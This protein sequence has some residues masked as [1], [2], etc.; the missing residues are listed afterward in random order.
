M[1]VSGAVIA[2]SLAVLAIASLGCA[3]DKTCRGVV[4]IGAQVQKA[5]LLK[6]DGSVWL[7]HPGAEDPTR[8]FSA[9]DA[10]GFANAQLC[11]RMSD[12]YVWC[13]P[14]YDQITAGRIADL[15]SVA[16][17]SSWWDEQDE[18]DCAVLQDGSL[19]CRSSYDSEFGQRAVGIRNVAVGAGHF[20][21]IAMDGTLDCQSE[22]GSPDWNGAGA[23]LADVV[24]VVSAAQPPDSTLR[25]A[26]GAVWSIHQL[27]RAYDTPI[28]QTQI[29]G[30]DGTIQ[31]MVGGLGFVCA[32]LSEGEVTC[33]VAGDATGGEVILQVDT[34]SARRTPQRIAS[35]PQPATALA[36][37]D[38]FVCALLRDA[39][40]WCWGILGSDGKSGR[41][42]GGF[43]ESC[44]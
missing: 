17:L 15:P 18:S 23:G 29:A 10:T 32:L 37:G 44:N 35:L 4:A 40:V 24:E 1:T 3:D 28:E 16:Q 19:T 25:T 20:C 14:S 12:R 34:Y 31:Q 42:K 8:K 27:G 2:R 43:V 41:A 38:L 30:I 11:L 9:P 39:T 36:A 21:A 7:W 6:A 26:S 13:D 33:W 22:G 5:A